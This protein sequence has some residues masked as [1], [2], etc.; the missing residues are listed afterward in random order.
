MQVPYLQWGTVN[1]GVLVGE[2]RVRRNFLMRRGQAMAV[3]L[4]LA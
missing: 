1:E 3:A 4:A 2:R